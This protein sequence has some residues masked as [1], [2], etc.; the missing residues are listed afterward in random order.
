MR[1]KGDSPRRIKRDRS[2]GR[3]FLESFL[4]GLVMGMEIWY[5]EENVLEG[6]MDIKQEEMKGPE[7]KG[8]KRNNV[9]DREAEPGREKFPEEEELLDREEL[10][11]EE[12]ASEREELPEEEES[13]D[14]PVKSAKENFYDSLPFTYRQVDIFCKA[15]I[16]VLA[17]IFLYY[18]IKGML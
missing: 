11:E 2:P 13:P 12:E 8:L 7:E 1:T 18:I 5:N 3:K 17:A 6:T 10:P 4:I 9:L 15:A 14:R 16:G